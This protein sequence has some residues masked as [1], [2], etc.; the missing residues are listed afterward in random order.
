[1]IACL[2]E[3]PDGRMKL[4]FDDV[5]GDSETNPVRWVFDWFYTHKRYDLE[6]LKVGL[7]EEE[8]Q[9]IGENV[10]SRLLALGG[11]VR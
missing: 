5:S 6:K 8:Y 9:L 3:C 7:S 10:V 1:M 4:V 2:V 11:H